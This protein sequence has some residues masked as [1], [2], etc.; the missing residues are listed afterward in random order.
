M[1]ADHEG[2]NG[3][4]SCR[5]EPH[6]IFIIIVSHHCLPRRSASAERARPNPS[7]AH[8]VRIDAHS[9]RK[10]LRNRMKCRSSIAPGGVRLSQTS[11][12]TFGLEQAEDVVLADCNCVR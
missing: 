10:E 3:V 1:Q 7:L 2:S 4:D 5:S 8:E 6:I 11:S 12:L 9:F